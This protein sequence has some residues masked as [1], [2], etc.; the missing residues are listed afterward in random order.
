MWLVSFSIDL[1][2]EQELL[3]PTVSV[4]QFTPLDNLELKVYLASEI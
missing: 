3:T 4:K 1:K 2:K